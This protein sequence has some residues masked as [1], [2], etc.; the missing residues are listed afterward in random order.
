M[1]LVG[2]FNNESPI[3]LFNVS[4]KLFNYKKKTKD[5]QTEFDM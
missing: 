3:L 1:D 2:D 5:V 4:Y